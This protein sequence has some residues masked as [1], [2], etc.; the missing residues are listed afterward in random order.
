MEIS[1]NASS[2]D[3]M[4]AGCM[5]PSLQ[6]LSKK[7]RTQMEI[8][9]AVTSSYLGKC[10]IL[11]LTINREDSLQKFRAH[12]RESATNLPFQLLVHIRHSIYSFRHVN[13]E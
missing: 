9:P 5:V 4:A 8:W 7:N 10:K 1:I 13:I 11:K 2:Y 6:N 12:S 3:S